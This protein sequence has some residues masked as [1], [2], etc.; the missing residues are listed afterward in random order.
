MGKLSTILLQYN[1]LFTH[2]EYTMSKRYN[3]CK[4]KGYT[5][6]FIVIFF[7]Y[8]QNIYSEF[9]YS[10]YGI[11]VS[12][13]PAIVQ[14]HDVGLSLGI[15]GTIEFHLGH[16]YGTVEFYPSILGIFAND[17]FY[18]LSINYIDTRYVF[19]NANETIKPYVGLGIG[20]PINIYNKSTAASLCLH[21]FA[22]L[23]FT[24]ADTF[25]PFL[26]VRIS[27]ANPLVFRFLN[28][29]ITIPIKK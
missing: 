21:Q 14:D 5:V 11:G 2:K 15:H 18:Q 22:G 25:T 4:K 10:G 20:I 7:I 13:S 16:D 3:V 1:N 19:P 9:R 27:F 8:A 17:D 26:E 29:G 28:A 12:A 6:L 24:I 23:S